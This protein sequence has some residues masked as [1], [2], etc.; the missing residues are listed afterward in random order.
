MTENGPAVT[1]SDSMK[2]FPNVGRRPILG[3]F[4]TNRGRL[5]KGGGLSSS[6][7]SL[8]L[9]GFFLFHLPLHH[10]PLPLHPPPLPLRV[11]K[12]WSFLVWEPITPCILS[13]SITSFFL[14]VHLVAPNPSHPPPGFAPRNTYN[15]CSLYLHSASLSSVASR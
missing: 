12:P 13:L 5:P 9:L 11:Y 3:N 10:P 4:V 15:L 14:C 7:S 1:Y 6:I 2:K 8:L